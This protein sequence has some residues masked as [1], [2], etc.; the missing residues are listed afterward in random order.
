MK[1]RWP[2][3]E[4]KSAEMVAAMAAVLVAKD[5]PWA[6]EAREAREPSAAQALSFWPWQGR[7]SLMEGRRQMLRLR[8][9]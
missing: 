2:M 1:G 9:R 7:V 8:R 5:G 4:E 6:G 3:E